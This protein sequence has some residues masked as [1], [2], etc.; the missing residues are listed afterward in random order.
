[1][2]DSGKVYMQISSFALSSANATDADTMLVNSMI[3]QNLL[4]K[5]ILF[6]AGDMSTSRANTL[7]T[8]AGADPKAFLNQLFAIL[9]SSDS[10][11]IEAWQPGGKYAFSFYKNIIQKIGALFNVPVT[12]ADLEGFNLHGSIN[13]DIAHPQLD[14]VNSWL[15]KTTK[16]NSTWT[17]D[18]LVFHVTDMLLHKNMTLTI[19][20]KTNGF[21]LS[22]KDDKKTTFDMS[23]LLNSTYTQIMRVRALLDGGITLRLSVSGKY[24]DAGTLNLVLPTQNVVPFESIIGS[25]SE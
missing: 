17:K 2:I 23:Y 4:G 3:Q 25:L 5:W 6:S 14:M 21:G 9:R 11:V 22:Y 24:Y 20:K 13:T 15:D 12:S 18:S 19:A 7:L 1:M 10:Y 8:S 16:I